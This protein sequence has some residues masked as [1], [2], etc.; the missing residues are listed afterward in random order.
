[1]MPGVEGLG[2]AFTAFG[3]INDEAQDGCVDTRRLR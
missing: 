1:M 2:E 3:H